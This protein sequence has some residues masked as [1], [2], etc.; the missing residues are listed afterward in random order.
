MNDSEIRELLQSSKSIAV[1][2]LSSNPSRA[3][4]GVSQ[5]MQSRGYKI[6]PV[7]PN[8][9][10]VLGERAFPSLD[11][12][13]GAIDIVNVFRRSEFVPSIVDAA[14]AKGARCVWMQQG[15]IHQ[16]AAANAENFGLLVVMDRCIG[17]EHRRLVRG[18]AGG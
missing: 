7:N 12:F 13:P 8:E 6:F 3:S 17:V 1:V 18:S 10:E 5:Y 2:G 11:A 9:V 15:V 16:E 4:F 14:I